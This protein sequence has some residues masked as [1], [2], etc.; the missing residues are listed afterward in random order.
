MESNS[1]FCPECGSRDEPSDLDA[2]PD[3][4]TNGDPGTDSSLRSRAI[5]KA[6]SVSRR[7]WIITAGAACSTLLIVGGVFWYLNQEDDKARAQSSINVI[8]S[9]EK[10]YRSSTPKLRYLADV[11]RLANSV[12]TQLPDMKEANST[13][14][15]ISDTSTRET[16]V[17]STRALIGGSA[18]LARMTDLSSRKPQDWKRHVGRMT[19][20]ASILRLGWP[21]LTRQA[22]A[23]GVS[24]LPA[25]EQLTLAVLQAGV[26]VGRAVRKLARWKAAAHQA[27]RTKHADLA[28][29]T[30]YSA[31]MRGQIAAYGQQRND[32]QAF[33]DHA[34]DG[35]YNITF[36]DAYAF[37][38]DAQSSRQ[39]VQSSMRAMTPPTSAL[40]AHS[41]MV[42][43][44]GSAVDALNYATSGLQ[45]Y[46]AD[47]GSYDQTYFS[48]RE[49][50]S[51]QEFTSLSDSAGAN[52]SSAV[53]SWE[54]G[55]AKARSEISHRKPPKKPKV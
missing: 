45:E 4:A 38:S 5:D 19:S 23:A 16:I 10:L 25:E 24:G 43:A 39:G 40:S 42:E 52:W 17:Q 35:G 20:A 36:D 31:A 41:G 29:L 12:Q 46:Q 54:A 18:A 37:V 8:A 55:I 44:I 6:Q 33:L 11:R 32:T 3:R 28:S 13:A 9:T 47:K 50:P 30:T 26:V 27:L 1:V 49:T 7:A 22:K 21:D 14:A 53:S 2:K 51:W 48:F 15:G 34:N